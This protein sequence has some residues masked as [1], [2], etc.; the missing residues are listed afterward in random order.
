MPRLTDKSFVYVPSFSTDVGRHL[1]KAKSA[2]QREK[3]IL[4]RA[5]TEA[6]VENAERDK[7]RSSV[8]PMKR[9]AQ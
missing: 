9:K 6:E 1:R 7:I 2:E 8:V 5:W 3:R 4:V